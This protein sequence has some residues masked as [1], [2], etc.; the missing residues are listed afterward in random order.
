MTIDDTDV[1]IVYIWFRMVA[2]TEMVTGLR[3]CSWAGMCRGAGMVAGLG[4]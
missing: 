1:A 3:W 2:G 4:W